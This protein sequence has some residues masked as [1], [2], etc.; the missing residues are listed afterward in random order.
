MYA[1]AL[2]IRNNDIKKEVFD[3]LLSL[4]GNNASHKEINGFDVFYHRHEN[5]EEIKQLILSL[6]TEFMVPIKGYISYDRETEKLLEELK[7]VTLALR[8]MG[9]EI[10]NLKE[11]LP[12]INDCALKKK[13][14][15]FILDGTGITIE[16]IREFALSDL[17]VSLASKKM[18]IHRNTMIYKLDRFYQ[19][20]HFDLRHFIDC[21]LLYSLI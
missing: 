15:D 19:D 21:H 2:Y 7:L 17:N 4:I 16:F 5:C 12:F 8:D 10:Y 14:L 13:L 3:V 9:N 6:S 11:L 18:H 1:V 20:T